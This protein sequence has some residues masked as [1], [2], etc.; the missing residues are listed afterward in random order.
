MIKNNLQ[1]L[2]DLLNQEVQDV[3]T[4]TQN[5]R[6]ISYQLIMHYDYHKSF[7]ALKYF[8][9]ILGYNINMT[10]WKNPAEFTSRVTQILFYIK[11]IILEH[12]LSREKHDRFESTLSDNP[13]IRLNKVRDL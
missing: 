6:K 11:I 12:Y 1:Y 3:K 9:E 7:S 2:I 5:I 13:H 8:N 10:R 4:I